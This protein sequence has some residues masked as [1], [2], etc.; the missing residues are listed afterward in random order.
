MP[1]VWILSSIAAK[2]KKYQVSKSIRLCT[3]VADARSKRCPKFAG[4]GFAA[5]WGKCCQ[6]FALL[7]SPLALGTPSSKSSHPPP[8][9]HPL[10]NRRNSFARAERLPS[11]GRNSSQSWTESSI[12]QAEHRSAMIPRQDPAMGPSKMTRARDTQ[13]RRR[14]SETGGGAVDVSGLYN[15]HPLPM[16]TTAT[17]LS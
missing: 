3:G 2:K 8:Q 12:G 13:R 5:G 9:T 17:Q 14:R 6:G 15:T 16:D 4:R 7:P 10:S 11:G 1:S